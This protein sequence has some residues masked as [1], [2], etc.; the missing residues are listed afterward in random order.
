[1]FNLRLAF[2]IITAFLEK[3]NTTVL[4]IHINYK[5]HSDWTWMEET[6]WMLDFT[7]HG[8]INCFDNFLSNHLFFTYY[9][10]FLYQIIL[11]AYMSGFSIFH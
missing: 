2:N 4:N 1:M 8:I 9:N 3:R 7:K 5:M 10:T 6:F 11:Y